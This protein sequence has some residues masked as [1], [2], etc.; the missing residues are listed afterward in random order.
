MEQQRGLRGP[1]RLLACDLDGT[2]LGDRGA[3]EAGVTDAVADLVVA[4]VP[5]VICTGR[6][7]AVARRLVAAAG[8]CPAVIASYHGGLVID[9][10]TD[11]PL[12]YLTLPHSSVEPLARHLLDCGL[13]LTLFEKLDALPRDAERP[14]QVVRLLAVGPAADVDSACRRVGVLIGGPAAGESARRRIDGDRDSGVSAD[15]EEPGPAVAEGPLIR[16]ERPFATV[17]DVRH[18]LATKDRGLRTAAR[19]LGVPLSA[20]LAAGD[21]PSDVPMLR[22]AGRSIAVGTPTGEAA[23]AADIVVSGGGLAACLHRMASP[24]HV[25]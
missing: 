21:G 17:L 12:R 3:P 5:L 22:A 4:G 6:P 19:A 2:L 9:E 18:R 10:R 14:A 15:D 7:H 11:Q 23:A 8:L 16:V 25:P 24:G 20:V 1:V 13:E